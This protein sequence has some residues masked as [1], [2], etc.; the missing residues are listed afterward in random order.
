MA[1]AACSQQVKRSQ[2]H[3][4]RL[5]LELT[6]TSTNLLIFLPYW[7]GARMTTPENAMTSSDPIT[8]DTTIAQV[9]A[10]LAADVGEEVVILHTAN[11]A[12]YDADP[13]GAQI[14]RTLGQPTTVRALCAALM[15]SYAVEATTC[16]EDVLAFLHTAY[17]EGLIR[18][19]TP[20]SAANV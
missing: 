8:L 6:L 14:W 17:Q 7:K 9:E 19:V 12:Y 10:L 18:I 5:T 16:Q 1:P 3:L 11:G 13:I 4:H 15:E 2:R 20:S